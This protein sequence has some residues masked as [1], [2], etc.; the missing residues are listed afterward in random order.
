[1]MRKFQRN[2][3]TANAESGRV[4]EIAQYILDNPSSY[5]FS[6]ITVS[7]NAEIKFEPISSEDIGMLKIPMD[8]GLS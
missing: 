1:M 8:A 5:I 4:P 7:I 3:G 2:E 6:A